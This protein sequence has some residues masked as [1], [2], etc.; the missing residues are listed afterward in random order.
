MGTTAFSIMI[1]IGVVVMHNHGDVP[2]MPGWARFFIFRLLACCLCQRTQRN[3][4]RPN[5]TAVE[6]I[7]TTTTTTDTDK[8]NKASKEL[9]KGD[10]T[11]AVLEQIHAVLQNPAT[12]ENNA[13]AVGI[14][15]WQ[16]GAEIVEAFCLRVILAFLFLIPLICLGI[17]PALNEDSI[18][19]P[20]E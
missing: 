6:S 4:E 14:N 10:E 19:H 1:S 5:D 17:V 18:L 16:H 13:R 8:R 12:R 20:R 9:T 2:R 3:K 7:T 11:L 15:E